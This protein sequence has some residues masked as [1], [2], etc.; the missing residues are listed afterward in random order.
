[1]MSVFKPF[2]AA[3][4]TV[5]AMFAGAPAAKASPD[6]GAAPKAE[7]RSLEDAAAAVKARGY[8]VREAEIDNGCYEIKATGKDGERVKFYLDPKSLEAVRNKSR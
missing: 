2:A 6:C 8:E 4:L 1:M 7:W 3:T 5:V